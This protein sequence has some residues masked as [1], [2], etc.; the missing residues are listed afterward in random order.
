MD[1]SQ[2]IEEITTVSVCQYNSCRDAGSEAVWEAFLGAELPEGVE[3]VTVGCQGQCSIAPT[4][5]VTPEEV[6]YY[7]VK[8]GDVEEIVEEHLKGG[9]PVE[10]KLNPRI[11]PFKSKP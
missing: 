9:K 5:R 2:K 10:A 4:V 11:H 8:P 6:W 1:D 7:R 3:V